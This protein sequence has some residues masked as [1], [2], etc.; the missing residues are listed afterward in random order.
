MDKFTK[1][2]MISATLVGAVGGGIAGGVKLAETKSSAVIE[3][4]KK[5]NEDLKQELADIKVGYSEEQLQEAIEN[6]KAEEKQKSQAEIDALKEQLK[7]NKDYANLLEAVSDSRN[8]VIR[9][10]SSTRFLIGT[11]KD[12]NYCTA[13]YS[14]D[15][16]GTCEIVAKAGENGI[17]EDFEIILNKPNN[18]NVE[19]SNGDI[20]I[21]KKD[22]DVGGFYIYKYDTNSLIEGATTGMN[23]SNFVD[24]GDGYAVVSSVSNK[25]N[26]T[27]VLNLIN[28][29]YK[30][31]TGIYSC[32]QVGKTAE[33]TLFAAATG[34][35]ALKF[36][37]Y[38]NETKELEML[39]SFSG[40]RA[41][42]KEVY[43]SSNGD[44]LF[45]NSVYSTNGTTG[46]F[47]Y[48]AANKTAFKIAT[49][50][51]SATQFYETSSGVILFQSANSKCPGMYAYDK[52]SGAFA[53]LSAPSGYAYGQYDVYTENGAGVVISSSNEEYTTKFFYAF[54]TGKITVYPSLD[55]LTAEINS[56]VIYNSV[57]RQWNQSTLHQIDLGLVDFEQIDTS[58]S[59]QL[60]LKKSDGSVITTYYFIPALIS[61]VAYNGISPTEDSNVLCNVYINKHYDKANS[62]WSFDVDSHCYVEIS[63]TENN[64]LSEV[65]T[66]T[67]TKV[68]TA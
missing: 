54:N 43:A 31:Y 6:A 22:A 38:N 48:S 61:G 40:T 62:T 19:M 30:E 29:T 39:D 28:Y 51:I 15:T 26:R 68:V 12:L 47:F 65:T 59:Y 55:N 56:G 8:S 2:F 50:V 60:Q 67:I 66:I 25:N 33:N 44:L 23:I 46:T 35:N 17:P 1:L 13:L 7:G 14:L 32:R 57:S 36:V 64:S 49:N 63:D 4:Q 58:A 53:Y 45:S 37:L 9:K 24:M 18:S 34:S 10:V 52:T 41:F 27:G 21:N 42:Y 20:L 16:N 11:L 3:Q 5:E